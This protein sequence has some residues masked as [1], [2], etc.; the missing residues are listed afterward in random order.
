MGHVWLV[1]HK[2]VKLI[3][4]C[5]WKLIPASSISLGPHVEYYN[6]DYR[7]GKL[8]YYSIKSGSNQKQNPFLRAFALLLSALCSCSQRTT[9][10]IPY[11][12]QGLALK[13]LLRV[14]SLSLFPFMHWR[15]KW[16]PIVVLLPGE[17]QGRG[18]LVGCRLWG[19]TE[20]DTIEAT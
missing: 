19:R 18:S 4:W 15:R 6:L 5:G 13:W 17:S 14:V 16:Q 7:R 20:L 10:L 11:L 1:G 9:W 8:L 12:P 3:Q 2:S